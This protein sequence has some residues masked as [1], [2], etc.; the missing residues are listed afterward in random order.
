MSNGRAF[1]VGGWGGAKN[2][3]SMKSTLYL[4]CSRGGE[5]HVGEGGGAKYENAPERARSRVRREGWGQEGVEHKKHA[6]KGMF[7]VLNVK[8]GENT[9]KRARSL[10]RREGWGQEGIG[11]KKHAL[12]GVFYVLDM[13]GGENAPR[14]VRSLVRHEG[15]QQRQGGGGYGAVGVVW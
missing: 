10:A 9:P 4:S 15:W 14:R 1:R 3:S 6:L 13:K 7:C 12:E 2:A 11:H 8:G 5:G